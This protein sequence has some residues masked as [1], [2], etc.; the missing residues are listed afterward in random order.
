MAS[1]IWP[2]CQSASFYYV[3]TKDQGL[4]KLQL[5]LNGLLFWHTV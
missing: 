3:L 5:W 1:K 2:V 4:T